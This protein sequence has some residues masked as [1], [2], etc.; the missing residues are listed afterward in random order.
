[1]T[2][3]P[4]NRIRSG[5]CSCRRY[6]R[7]SVAMLALVVL[8][9]G[10]APVSLNQEDLESP[11]RI[12]SMASDI[13]DRAEAQRFLLDAAD[14]LQNQNS[15]ADARQLLRSERLDPP[16]EPLRLQ[17]MLLSMAGAAALED[18]DW[19]EELADSLN[20]THF[21]QYREDLVAQAARLQVEIFRLAGQPLQAALTLLDTSP[22]LVAD[23]QSRNDQIWQLLKRTPSEEIREYSEKAIGYDTQGWLE[24]A[25]M[26]RGPE[27]NLETRGKAVR[28]WQFNWPGHP[29][30]SQ[31][32]DEL[33]MLTRL[34]QE[35]PEKIYLALPLTGPLAGAGAAIRDGFMAAFYADES[36]SDY[37]IQITVTDTTDRRFADLYEELGKESPDLIVGPLEKEALATVMNRNSM[38]VPL[39]ALNYSSQSPPPARLYQFGLSAEDEAR[40]IAS[41]LQSEGHSQVL[42]LVPEGDWGSRVE[43]ALV[44]TLDQQG[45]IALDV[46]RFFRS[47]NFRE[48]T[49]DLLG[50]NTSR[51]RAI[52]VERTIGLNIEFEPRR[53]QDVDAIIMVAQPTIARQFNPL[54]AFYF[55]GD[56]PVYAPSLVYEGRA[57][58][59]RDRDLN[60]V[61]FTDIPWVL[62]PDNP[63]RE[64][65]TSAF[66]NMSGQL[67][68]LFAMGADAYRL[69]AR[70]PLL[71]Q[72]EN[73]A[74]QGL[75]GRLTMTENGTIRREQLW[76]VFEQGK[77]VLLPGQSTGEQDESES[78][79]QNDPLL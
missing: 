26:L 53:R 65:A 13:R 71:E 15:H 12:I 52:A 43:Q 38:P 29:A 54:F 25:L 28:E 59:S 5:H 20:V 75:T 57:D 78:D 37:E 62:N 10:C 56:L 55:G 34:S 58:P 23:A 49:A 31:L 70:L 61:R 4:R 69:S 50:I 72:V 60:Q 39:L 73:S 2:D 79:R 33:A 8:L 77:P 16:L 27:M 32:P 45:G 42:V 9:A 46:R 47:D 64:A 44:E 36:A 74:I 3:Q 67:G 14:R 48:V 66:P 1:M 24:L 22:G 35:R 68:R 51:E 30:A 41:R 17:Y 21:R 63:F 6:T 7:H 76:A 19:A 40:Q 11:D 18:R